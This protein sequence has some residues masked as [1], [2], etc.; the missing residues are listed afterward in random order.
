MSNIIV[1]GIYPIEAY[2]PVHLIEMIIKNPPHIP[3]I[4]EFTQE[5]PGEP[6]ENWPVP[7]TEY[8]LDSTGTHIISED[9]IENTK[10]ELWA[11]DVR[12]VFFFHFLDLTKP[13]ITPFGVVD[14]PQESS[15]PDRLNIIDYDP[16]T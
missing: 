11:G 5:I 2:E 7:Y 13:M 4:N 3:D 12:L 6:R 16:P 9:F 8:I 14:L 1:I 15:L 10:P